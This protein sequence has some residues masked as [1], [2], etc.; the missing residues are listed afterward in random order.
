MSQLRSDIWCA[1]F[2]RRHND[3]GNFCVIARKGHAIAGQVWVEVDHLDGTQSLY[4]PA[5]MLKRKTKLHDLIFELRLEKANPEKIE[6]RLKNELNFDPDIWII[7]LQMRSGD[8]G[9]EIV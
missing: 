3:L 4:A 5:P 7:A 6:Q 1:S 8:I 2:I 9:L